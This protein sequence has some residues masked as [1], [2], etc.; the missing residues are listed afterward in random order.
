M[1]YQSFEMAAR[2]GPG[3][4]LKGERK[5]LR[6]ATLVNSTDRYVTEMIVETAM[7]CIIE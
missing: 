5:T 6:M 3:K 4:T 7:D 2:G 1:E